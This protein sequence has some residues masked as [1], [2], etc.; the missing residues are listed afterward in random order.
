VK[1]LM[2][3]RDYLVRVV[4]E[5]VD[6]ASSALR[7]VSQSIAKTSRMA[8]NASRSFSKLTAGLRKVG[9]IAGGV[10]T[11][12][13]GFNILNEI[14]SGI[15]ES[16]QAFAEFEAESMKLAALTREAGQ[17]VEMLAEAYRVAASAASRDFAVS[18][19]EAL[20]AL[21]ALV[22]AGLSG[23]DAIQALGAVVQMARHVPC[24][25]NIT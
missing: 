4:V 7:S 6:R 20:Q 8:E 9:E 11:G 3:G 22:K 1:G 18:A 5:G 15:R 19:G 12:L 14:S 16:V 2:A 23:R 13:I 10:I 21:E 24:L 17:D 25:R